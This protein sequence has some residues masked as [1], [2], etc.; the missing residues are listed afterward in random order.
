M[1]R[2]INIAEL[3]ATGKDIYLNKILTQL[4]GLVIMG[5]SNFN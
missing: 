4:I 1:K 3:P 2:L 5:W